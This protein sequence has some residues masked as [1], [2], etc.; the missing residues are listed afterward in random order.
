[1]LGS[2]AMGITG[3][4]GLGENSGHRCS[5]ITCSLAHSPPPPAGPSLGTCK[6]CDGTG[7]PPAKGLQIRI[8]F[9][10]IFQIFVFINCCSHA[11]FSPKAVSY[12]FQSSYRF[13]NLFRG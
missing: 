1:L 11:S 5:C 4:A 7:P 6:L 8:S 12:L 3:S 9:Q 13:V 10:Y 2:T